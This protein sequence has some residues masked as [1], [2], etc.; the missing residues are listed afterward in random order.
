MGNEEFHNTISRVIL[1][2]QLMKISEQVAP[3]FRNRK[4]DEFGNPPRFLNVKDIQYSKI[5]KDELA[6]YDI[7][8]FLLSDLGSWSEQIVIREFN[9][10]ELLEDEIFR[11]TRLEQRCLNFKNVK[12]L[13]IISVDKENYRVIYEN[14][15]GFN[16]YQ[17]GLSQKLIDYTLGQITSIY[18]GN[19]VIGLEQ[20]T[21]RELLH[22]LINHLPFTLEER[23]SIQNLLEPQLNYLTKTKGGYLPCSLFDPNK[24]Q[25]VPSLERDSISMDALANQGALLSVILL[26]KPEAF[27][28]DRMTDVATIYSNRAFKEFLSTGDVIET[29]HSIENFLQ[30]YKDISNKL[31]TPSLSEIFP[32]GITLD[33]QMLMS[34][35]LVEITKLQGKPGGKTGFENK[36]PI[37][38]SYLLLTQTPF[39]SIKI[40]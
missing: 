15:L 35:Y 6:E 26:E 10:I 28:I 1:K 31:E 37:R 3:F 8:I 7:V 11:Y 27:V 24:L 33:L 14:Q 39:R 36:D 17:L 25:F 5:T 34:Y 40:D 19:E 16:I 13:P 20:I 23:E 21:V 22:F 18:H 38:Y 12:I 2:D 4:K 9:K 29:K 30:G 32:E